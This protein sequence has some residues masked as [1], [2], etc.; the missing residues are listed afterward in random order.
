M[1]LLRVVVLAR[2]ARSDQVSRYSALL[3]LGIAAYVVEFGSRLR[4]R[5]S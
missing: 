1:L 3:L 4:Q 2:N 5:W